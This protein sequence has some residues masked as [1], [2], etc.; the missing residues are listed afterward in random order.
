M[1]LLTLA[2]MLKETTL[3]ELKKRKRPSPMH[4]RNIHSQ[5]RHQL[6]SDCESY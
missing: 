1:F 2:Q 3:Q 6:T 4:K 5:C